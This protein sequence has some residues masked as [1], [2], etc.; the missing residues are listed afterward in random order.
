[1]NGFD[2]D[3]QFQRVWAYDGRVRSATVDIDRANPG[4]NHRGGLEQTMRVSKMAGHLVVPLSGIGDGGL[5]VLASSSKGAN[6][7]L[8]R[9]YASSGNASISVLVYVDGVIDDEADLTAHS[10]ELIA[11]LNELVD[12]LRPR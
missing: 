9:A 7:P 10:S 3:A 6:R 1:M 4:A 12:D 2:N 5:A 11:A 8:V